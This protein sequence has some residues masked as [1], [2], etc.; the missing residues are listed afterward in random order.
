MS[1]TDPA[2][3]AAYLAS[4]EEQAERRGGPVRPRQR[5]GFLERL[6]DAETLVAQTEADWDA[7]ARGAASARADLPG[8]EHAHSRY[9]NPDDRH[10]YVRVLQAEQGLQQAEEAYRQARSSLNEMLTEYDAISRPTLGL[11]PGL[12]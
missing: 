10:R 7:A 4:L 1:R 12:D 8:W 2:G 6:A 3:R 11:P 5:G 9:L